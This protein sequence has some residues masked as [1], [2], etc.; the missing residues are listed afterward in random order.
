[1]CDQAVVSVAGH[2]SRSRLLRQVCII[3]VFLATDQ[4][5]IGAPSAVE[6]KETRGC[7]IMR[8]SR[9]C[10]NSTVFYGRVVAVTVLC[11]VLNC[12]TAL[13]APDE[14]GARSLFNSTCASCHGRNGA[15]SAVG[16]SLNAPDLG[17]TDVQKHANTELQEI[18]SDGKGNMPPFK[19]KLSAAQ[20]DSLI[21][22]VRAF[23]KQHK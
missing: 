13:A 17:S 9:K 15:P 1:M 18:I 8:I 14:Q 20:I 19:D 6:E 7:L 2:V 21:A 4:Q 23:A 10:E 11:V 12:A 5:R 3:N 22:Y 16:K